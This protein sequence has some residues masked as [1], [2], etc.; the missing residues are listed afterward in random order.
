MALIPNGRRGIPIKTVTVLAV[1][2]LASLG[3]IGFFVAFILAPEGRDILIAAT[4]A[5]GFVAT[6][7]TTM[8][9]I[10]RSD[11]AVAAA[12]VATGA[13]EAVKEDVKIVHDAVN[14][15]MDAA[16]VARTDQATA[17]ATLIERAAA[18]IKIEAARAATDAATAAATAATLEATRVAT[19][20]MRVMVQ[21]AVATAFAAIPP[22]ALPAPP[23]T[24]I[25]DKED[26]T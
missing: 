12:Q 14:S 4:L 3:L 22:A 18:D 16:I 13:V 2:A 5:F 11:D 1:G 19:E 8:L 17:E 7:V 23:H 24:H 10:S 20:A 26:L 6:M 25:P 15:K 21:Q 9:N